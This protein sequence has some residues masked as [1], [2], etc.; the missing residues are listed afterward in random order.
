M[1]RLNS[2]YFVLILEPALST[3]LDGYASPRLFVQAVW[4]LYRALGWMVR[5]NT[6]HPFL[7][8]SQSTPFS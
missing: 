7:E 1:Y 2:V 8:L 5:A 3:E 4:A 6:G